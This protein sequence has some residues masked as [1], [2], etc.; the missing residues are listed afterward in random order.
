MKFRYQVDSP[1]KC[2][3]V[4]L[5]KSVIQNLTGNQDFICRSFDFCP[6]SSS[7]QTFFCNFYDLT[8]SDPD[9]TLESAPACEHYSSYKI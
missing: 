2:A 7:A 3:S 4:C 9:I 1:S 6:D 5:D 8:I